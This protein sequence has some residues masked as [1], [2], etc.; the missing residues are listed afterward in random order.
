MH[1]LKHPSTSTENEH[2]HV[3]E[4]KISEHFSVKLLNRFKPIDLV[5][6]ATRRGMLGVSIKNSRFTNALISAFA[7]MCS[8]R[9]AQG[10]VTIVDRPY[11]RNISATGR[12]PGWEHAEIE[13]LRR[14]AAE[15]RVRVMRMLAKEGAGQI[16]LLDWSALAEMTPAWL[17]DE[18]RRGWNRR[19]P[20]YEDILSET[21]AVI[22]SIEK[23]KL[24]R[25]AEF[26]LEELPVLLHLYYFSGEQVVD[27]YPGPP[28]KLFWKLESGAYAEEL[29]EFMRQIIRR[30]GLI[31]AHIIEL[32]DQK[33]TLNLSD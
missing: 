9:L 21:R 6:L 33:G 11:E 18:I 10:L 30:E 16:Q 26:V 13:K 25:Y 5:D 17:V 29:P 1:I 24:E 27:F 28:P 8:D 32:R 12:G 2:I 23:S 20:F 3:T 15:T 7:R 31:Y 14:I 4:L 19:G 22:P